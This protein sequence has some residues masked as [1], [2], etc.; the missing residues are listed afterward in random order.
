LESAIVRALRAPP[1]DEQPT[2]SIIQRAVLSRA[3]RLPLKAGARV[4]D[5]PS[6]A[7]A[8]TAAL[9]AL[10]LEAWGAD[11]VPPEG[12]ASTVRAADLNQPL[13]WPDE[14]FDAVFSVEGIEHLENPFGF[15]REVRRVLR[16]RGTFVLTTP[17][18]VSLRSRVRFLG[19]GFF[20]QDPRPLNESGRHPLHHINLRTFAELRHALHTSG[21]EIGEAGHT[22]VK[23]VSWLYAPYVPWVA[24]YTLLAFRKEKDPA[25]RAR[26]GEIRRTLLSRSLLFGENLML[27]ATKR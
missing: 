16:G 23:P 4:L 6:G 15:L 27:V 25:Q 26:N 22:H 24:L 13:P 10:G 5:A 20:H 3:A 11:L 14:H 21:L 17:N 9:A 8:L 12:G 7:G 18:T 2:L 19:S 1:R